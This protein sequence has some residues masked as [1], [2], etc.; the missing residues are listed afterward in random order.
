MRLS[1]LFEVLEGKKQTKIIQEYSI[2]Q[3]SIEQIFNRIVEEQYGREQI[4]ATALKEK[5]MPSPKT[6]SNEKLMMEME[7]TSQPV[8]AFVF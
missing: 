7:I 2:R 3:G 6:K 8:Q 4:E 5:E 1:E